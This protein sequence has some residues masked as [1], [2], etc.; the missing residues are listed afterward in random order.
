MRYA[1]ANL[2]GV[3]RAAL[4]VVCDPHAAGEPEQPLERQQQPPGVA[5]E[6]RV[7]HDAA[8]ARAELEGARRTG[9]CGGEANPTR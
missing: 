9:R 8:A 5:H 1:I 6:Q 2:D 7:A 4:A 3:Q